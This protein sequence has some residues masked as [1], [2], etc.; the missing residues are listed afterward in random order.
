MMDA[1]QKDRPHIV[2][3]LAA[4]AGVRCSIENP[5]AFP[6]SNINGTFKLLEVARAY[7]PVKNF[8]S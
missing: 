1:F 3:H 2:I 8:I 4:R 7:P 5:R 6:E